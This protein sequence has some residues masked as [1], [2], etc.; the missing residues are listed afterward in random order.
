MNTFVRSDGRP[1]RVVPGFRDH[2]L[3]SRPS[4]TPRPHWTPAEYAHAADT[5]LERARRLVVEVGKRYDRLDGAA[6]LDVGCGDGINCLVMA[7]TARRAVGVDLRLPLFEPDEPGAQ[8]RQLSGLVLERLDHARPLCDALQRL[9]VRFVRADATR[10]SFPADSFDVLLSRSAM[11]H[12]APVE[13]A[14]AE[15]ARVV[16]HGGVIHHGIDPYFW[17]RGCHK[18]GLVDIPWAHARLSLEDFRRFVTAS[19]GEAVAAKR[20]RRL[21]TLNRL[22]LAQWRVVVEAG[23]FEVLEWTEEPSPYAVA[24]LDEYPEVLDSLADGVEPRDL[25]HGRLHIW[26]RVTK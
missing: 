16:R 18:R 3:A 1:V 24:L 4:V 20:C 5:K 15:M 2:L 23:P 17:L 9:R 12:I 25:V 22:T 8:A 13:R 26:L 6:V 19:E 11:E 21:E 14:L 7:S 10:L